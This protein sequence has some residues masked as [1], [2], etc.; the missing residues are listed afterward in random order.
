MRS[1]KG[2]SRTAL[3][4]VLVIIRVSPHERILTSEYGS[5]TSKHI[6][7]LEQ[8]NANFTNEKRPRQMARLMTNDSTD[9]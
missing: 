7:D 1:C 3:L 6:K 5:E 2:N 4:P 9:K 8:H